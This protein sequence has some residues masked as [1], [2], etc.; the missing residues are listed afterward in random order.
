M[1]MGT[2]DGLADMALGG[3]VRLSGGLMGA[4]W[5]VGMGCR[6]LSAYT[7]LQRV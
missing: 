6:I 2:W 5:Y 4:G 1:G 7:G 3:P